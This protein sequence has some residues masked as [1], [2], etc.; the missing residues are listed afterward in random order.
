MAPPRFY[1]GGR[2]KASHVVQ[3]ASV[4]VPFSIEAGQDIAGLQG[5]LATG[6]QDAKDDLEALEFT[7][8]VGTTVH[9]Q[10]LLVGAT[11][12]TSTAATGAFV[13][14]DLY[15]LEQSLPPRFRPRASLVAVKLKVTKNRIGEA[16]RSHPM[17]FSGRLQSFTA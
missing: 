5:E 6:I 13:I 9:P 15:S 14:G 11:S 10:G 16:Y 3:K 1:R 2:T 4:F 12:T 8:G 17:R 7:T